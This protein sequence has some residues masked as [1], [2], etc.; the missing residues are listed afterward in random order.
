MP[1]NSTDRIKLRVVTPTGAALDAECDSVRLNA[2]AG[3]D[4]E[5]GMLGIR[6]G[7][8]PALI[9]LERGRLKAFLGG[10]PVADIGVGGGFATVADG[11]VTVLTS[12]IF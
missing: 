4:G 7:H 11:S 5:P 12:E 6:R 10:E 1:E 8:L 9:L 2:A 3:E